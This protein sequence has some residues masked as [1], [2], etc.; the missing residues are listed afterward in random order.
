MGWLDSYEDGESPLADEAVAMALMPDVLEDL[1][2]DSLR[3]IMC[4]TAVSTE[5]AAAGAYYAHKQ[6]KFWKILYET[7]LTPELMQPQQYRELLKHRIGLT[8][9]VKTHAGMD[10]QIPLSKFRKDS[11]ARLNALIT[12]YRP[13]FLAF[14]SKMAGQSFLGGKRDYG[15]QS[16]RIAG[17][18]MW[19]L[20][21]T[22]G[23]ANGA[24]RPEIWHQF[25]D[26]VR[27]VVG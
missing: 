19:I 12:R 5:S 16:E 2:Q 10:H 22:S 11:R 17:T 14:T 25:A 15:E 20:P 7:R 8:D 23:A 26:Q 1:L 27:A 6:N 24:W 13:G 21:S 4:G 3:I 18:R 9:F